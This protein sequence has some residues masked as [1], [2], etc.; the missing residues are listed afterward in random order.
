MTDGV[1]RFSRHPIYFGMVLILLGIAL[2]LGSLTPFAVP[3]CLAVFIQF[4]FV[5]P[6]EYDMLEQFGDEYRRYKTNVRQWV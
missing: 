4:A 6:E 2:A 1:F 3:I 5:V